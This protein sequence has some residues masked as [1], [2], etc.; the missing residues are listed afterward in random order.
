MPLERPL[1]RKA[2]AS[3]HHLAPSVISIIR[4]TNV[5]SQRVARNLGMHVEKVTWYAAN[6]VNIFRVAIDV[7][8]VSG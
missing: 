1:T 3:T 5:P 4:L 8:S 6:E 7:A 2:F